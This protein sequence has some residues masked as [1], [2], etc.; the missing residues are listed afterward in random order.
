MLL[1]DSNGRNL[2]KIFFSIHMQNSRKP[3]RVTT[4]LRLAH[5]QLAGKS[6]RIRATLNKGLQR[7]GLEE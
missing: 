3:Q 7:A 6:K 1:S 5:S 2:L 4:R